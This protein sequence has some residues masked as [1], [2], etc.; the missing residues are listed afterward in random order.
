[1][2]ATCNSHGEALG[3]VRFLGYLEDTMAQKL[4]TNPDVAPGASGYVRWVDSTVCYA[5]VTD[6]VAEFD[7]TAAERIRVM[8]DRHRVRAQG[9][10]KL[11][12]D[13]TQLR[14]MRDRR[15]G[16][17][18]EAWEAG[19]LL[20]CILTS[21]MCVTAIAFF[22]IMHLQLRHDTGVTER[23]KCAV[24]NEQYRLRMEEFNEEAGALG[25]KGMAVFE[26]LPY[27]RCLLPGCVGNDVA[28]ETGA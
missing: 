2:G 13:M 25:C 6:G 9:A 26:R 23:F 7:Q 27:Y 21:Y 22:I 12:H 11:M 19:V 20:E 4:E 18:I 3:C 8:N 16:E 17:Q 24:C 10:T 28:C 15:H 1:V 14:P 5:S